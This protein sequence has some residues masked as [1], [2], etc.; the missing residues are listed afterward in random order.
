MLTGRGKQTGELS[1][2]T[3]RPNLDQRL[4]SIAEEALKTSK[5]AIARITSVAAGN[6]QLGNSRL[7]FRYDE[8]IQKIAPASTGATPPIK[9]SPGRTSNALSRLLR[10]TQILPSRNSAPQYFSPQIHS[11]PRALYGAVVLDANKKR[12]PVSHWRKPSLAATNKCLARSNKSR[13]A[14]RD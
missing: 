14:Q 8:A 13:T 3:Y 4:P 12:R 2:A 5:I 6:N 10:G 11:P 9:T 1:K 7:W